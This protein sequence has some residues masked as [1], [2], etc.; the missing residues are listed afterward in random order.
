M[1]YGWWLGPGH[2]TFAIQGTPTL[3]IE[4]N[5]TNASPEV[6][7][8]YYS[9]SLSTLHQSTLLFSSQPLPL[10]EH[11]LNFTNFGSLLA[12]D[13]FKVFLNSSTTTT[14][15]VAH[16]TQAAPAAPGRQSP[17]VLVFLKFEWRKILHRI[18]DG[19]GSC[20]QHQGGC[21]QGCDGGVE[22]G[23]WC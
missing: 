9:N 23:S 2:A 5:T 10:G 11:V 14:S 19:Q 6:F 8:D 16:R 17:R 1:A 15:N 18:E 12:V 4:Q 13:Y 7:S 22:H 3:S 20:A 21:E